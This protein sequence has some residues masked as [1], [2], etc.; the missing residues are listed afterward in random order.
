[1]TS[2]REFIAAYHAR[3]ASITS[4]QPTIRSTMASRLKAPSISSRVE[5]DRCV[6]DL[7][8]TTVALRRLEARRDAQIQTV[9][10]EYEPGVREA[11]ARVD[12]LTL[13]AEK[14]AEDHR[15]ELFPGKSKS[16]ETSLSI[17]GFRLGNPTLRLL[18]RRCS[19]DGVVAALKLVLAGRFIRKTEEADKEA[20]KGANLPRET[21]EQLGLKIDQ[22]EAFFVEPKDKPSETA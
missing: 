19:W 17:F 10:A 2:N 21:L 20:I 13:L 14:Y 4:S 12:A 1:M 5:F 8:R 16:A 7:A 3:R 11:S 15:E 18:N 6:D 9:R 22:A